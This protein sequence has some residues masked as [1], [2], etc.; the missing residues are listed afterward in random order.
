MKKAPKKPTP[1]T[2]PAVEIARAMLGPIREICDKVAA[3]APAFAESTEAE[4]AQMVALASEVIEL[5]IGRL[6]EAILAVQNKDRIAAG[7]PVLWTRAEI[8]ISQYTLKRKGVRW[9]VVLNDREC[10][11]PSLIE[12]LRGLLAVVTAGR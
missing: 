12:A 7:N 4:V 9:N 3:K 8:L 6:C 2:F 11:A 5:E 1:S 10:T